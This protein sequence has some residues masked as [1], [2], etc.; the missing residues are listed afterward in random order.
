M[1][2]DHKRREV[3]ARLRESS[4]FIGRLSGGATPQ[5]AFD[6]FERILG[7]IDYEHGN[8]FDT[9]AELIDRP[10]CTVASVVLRDDCDEYEVELSCGDS[11]RWLGSAKDL[12]FC[13]SCGR[14]VV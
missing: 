12:A 10:T 3:A 11:I 4:G 2:D 5:N 8:V 1:I 13:P 6:V 7:C 14:K 9:L